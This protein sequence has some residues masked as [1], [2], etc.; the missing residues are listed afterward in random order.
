MVVLKRGKEFPYDDNKVR[1]AIIAAYNQIQFPDFEE[2]NFMVDEIA[3]LVWSKAKNDRI[4]V[5]TVANCV[6]SV[7]YREVPA[8]ARIYSQYRINRERIKDNPT[9]IEKVLY[10][11][12]EVEQENANKNP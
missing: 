9:E 8:V 12:P 5:E 7:L 6:M 10:G 3:D 11:D 4:D 2:I 1:R